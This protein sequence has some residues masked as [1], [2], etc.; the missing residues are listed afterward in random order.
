MRMADYASIF[1]VVRVNVIS[2]VIVAV[3]VAIVVFVA[4]V[5][6]ILHARGLTPVQ[7]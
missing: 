2:A 6:A 4:V 3:F 5:A 7:I 1:L